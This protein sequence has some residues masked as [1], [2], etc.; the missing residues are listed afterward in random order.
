MGH[1][2]L[3]APLAEVL[4]QDG[5]GGEDGGEVG[6]LPQPGQA[7]T[8]GAGGYQVPHAQGGATSL[9]WEDMVRTRA[10]G[11]SISRRV[12]RPSL[13]AQEAVGDV[14][15]HPE[16]VPQPGPAGA[17]ACPGRGDPGRVLEV[18][19]QVEEGRHLALSSASSALAG[20]S[21]PPAGPPPPPRAPAGGRP[22][23]RGRSWGAPRP[24][25][26]PG[27]RRCPARRSI[28]CRA[29]W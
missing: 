24:R 6:V 8:S 7:A 3:Q 9:L 22:R 29:S 2:G 5:L 18:R 28:S 1:V 13:V 21:R 16:L 19:D 14:L 20:R 27:G 26:G 10:P 11:W 23:W 12:G 15:H 17:G 4:V 25:A